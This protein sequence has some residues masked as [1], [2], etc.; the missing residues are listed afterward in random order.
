MSVI[1]SDDSKKQHEANFFANSKDSK[2]EERKQKRLDA[3]HERKVLRAA[4][5][6]SRKTEKV[7]KTLDTKKAAK[8]VKA[9][10]RKHARKLARRDYR[11]G[12]AHGIKRLFTG[13]AKYA[14]SA[15]LFILL[16]AVINIIIYRCIIIPS[17]E[18][19]ADDEY[20]K[21]LEE[22][23]LIVEGATAYA[24]YMSA[25]GTSADDVLTYISDTLNNQPE[26][27]DARFILSVYYGNYLGRNKNISLGLKYLDNLNSQIKD[28]RFRKEALYNAYYELYSI[29]QDF[30]NGNKYAKDVNAM[31]R[32]IVKDELITSE[33]YYK[34]WAEE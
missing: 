32:R 4:R 6:E 23:A 11:R 33:E 9:S 14:I 7:V 12:A 34:Q 17:I 22:D 5:R 18:Q 20:A 31:R 27:S 19:R 2:K 10:E 15:L 28:I 30:D 24:S 26:G 16:A 13:R 21:Y 8:T 3:K 29:N 1:L 25:N